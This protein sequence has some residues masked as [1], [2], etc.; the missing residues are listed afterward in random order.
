MNN[1][2]K[3]NRHTARCFQRWRNVVNRH[4]KLGTVDI[5]QF[6]ISFINESLSVFIRQFSVGKRCP[7]YYFHGASCYS[8]ECHKRVRNQCS[9]V[10]DF[11][12]LII[13]FK[14][15][16][17]KKNKSVEI[18]DDSF[19]FGLFPFGSKTDASCFFHRIKFVEFR[20]IVKE[21]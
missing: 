7:A 16:N 6:A 4:L 2:I 1:R 11:L 10:T 14:A 19:S 21:C 18:I 13:V 17:F 8:D 5:M 15:V 20:S 12:S 3:V 9:L